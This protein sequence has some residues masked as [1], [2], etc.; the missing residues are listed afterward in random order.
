MIHGDQAITGS[1]Q[2]RL[3]RDAAARALARLLEAPS[4]ETP[5]T[6]GVLGGWGTGKTSLMRL[7]ERRLTANAQPAETA[8]LTLWFDAW[9]YARQEQSLWRALLLKVTGE[10]GARAETLLSTDAARDKLK[11]EL[12]SLETSLYRSQTR[13]VHDGLKVNWGEALPVAAHLLAKTFTGGALDLAKLK[14][15]LTGEDPKE[16]AKLIE[17]RSRETY[18]EEVRSLEQF[19]A[20][21]ARA[22]D[23]VGVGPPAG[24]GAGGVRRR[25]YVFVDDLDRCL[26]EDAVAAVEAIKLFLDLP[27]C[28]FILGMDGEVIQAGIRARYAPYVADGEARFRAA[29]YLDKIIQV[30]FRLPP[31]EP[32]QVASFLAPILA[33]DGT[34]LAEDAKD[35][36][37][38][39]VPDNPR[40]LKRVLNVLRL[41]ADLDG[42]ADPPSAGETKETAAARKR[43]RRNLAK[44][45][46]L[47]VCFPDAYRMVTDQGVT[48]LKALEAAAVGGDEAKETTAVLTPRLRR[49]LG[50]DE[51][52]GEAGEAEIQR[53]LS[54]S[55]RFVVPPP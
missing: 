44:L 47:Q 39:A 30:P 53:L 49:L 24:D 14:E 33:M 50:E 18:V 45:V 27:G 17:R 25:L 1:D 51:R 37:Q 43:R 8:P 48:A 19:R 13:K 40:A 52:L 15:D 6:V 28:V 21:F 9:A 11:K 12:E 54:L 23:L 4:L 22:L 55:R 31:L 41:S 34:G 5:L 26:P 38:I 29:D 20:T 35:L 7:L 46:L 16:V 3:G 32:A 2:D 42:C 10:L 36:I